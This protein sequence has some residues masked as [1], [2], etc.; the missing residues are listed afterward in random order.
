MNGCL[1]I[2]IFSGIM[3]GIIIGLVY[4]FFAWLIGLIIEYWY[5]PVGI[6]S[7]LV[8]FIAKESY[9]EKLKFVIY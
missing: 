2:L 8:I 4:M 1:G 7:L 3:A 9:P 6:I 5:I